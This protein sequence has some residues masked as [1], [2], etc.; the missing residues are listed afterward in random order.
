RVKVAPGTQPGQRVRLKSKGM[1]VLRTKDFGDLYVQLD[2]ETPQNLSKR[3][4][5]LLEEFHRDST[6]D[7]SP[8]SDGFFAKLKNLFE[9]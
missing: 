7:N 2:V 9:T 3:Q 8:T 6:K 5:E 1:P 4:R